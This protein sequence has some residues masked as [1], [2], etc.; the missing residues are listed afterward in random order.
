[1]SA[2]PLYFKTP[3]GIEPPSPL[4]Y[5]VAKNGTFLVNKTSLF[6]A[7][8]P[9]TEVAGLA[10]QDPSLALHIPRIP[11]HVMEQI[12]GFFQAIYDKWQ[13]EAIAF[14]YYAPERGTYRIDIPPQTLFGVNHRGRWRIQRR[15]AYG[16]LPRSQGSIKVGDAHSHCDLPAFFSCADDRDDCVED[17]LHLVMGNL[18]CSRPDLSM[19]FVTGGTRFKLPTAMVAEDF[20]TPCPPPEE[21]LKQV[22]CREDDWEFF[23]GKENS[24]QNCLQQAGE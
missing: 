17:G 3:D 1:M 14:L 16:Y 13:G 24:K 20:S 23:G 11:Q 2:I 15:V 4:Y 18:D 7:V 5:L 19:S 6:V 10:A 9:V 21:W 22:T 12:Y 8:T